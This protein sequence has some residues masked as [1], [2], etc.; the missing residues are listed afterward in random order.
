MLRDYVLG[1]MKCGIS[2]MRAGSSD[3]ADSW[4]MWFTYR[5]SILISQRVVGQQA[6]DATLRRSS[7]LQSEMWESSHLPCSPAT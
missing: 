5:G 3:T 7:D 6:G 4:R 2:D 1:G